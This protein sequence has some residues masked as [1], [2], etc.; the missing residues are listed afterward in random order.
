MFYHPGQAKTI[1]QFSKTSLNNDEFVSDE[2]VVF[3]PGFFHKMIE[4]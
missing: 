3:K 4:F 1:H 2:N